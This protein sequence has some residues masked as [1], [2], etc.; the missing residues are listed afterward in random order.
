MKDCKI[1]VLIFTCLLFSCKEEEPAI[2]EKDSLSET[3]SSKHFVYY[4]SKTDK[5]IID[6]VW[7][8]NYYAW[9][10]EQLEVSLSEKIQYH[11]Y[12]DNEHIGRVTGKSGNGF[13]ELGTYK[14]HTIW[15]IDNHECVHVIATQ[16]IGHPPALF[17][18]G[19]AVA[20]QANYF[21]FPEFIPD[22]NGQDFNLLSRNYKQS[23]EIPALDKLLGK[24][25]YWEYSSNITY[26]V[27]GSFV[28][29]L[30][31]QYSLEK[32]KSFMAICD[33]ND[34]KDKIHNDFY[35]TYGFTIENAWSEWENFI[36]NYTSVASL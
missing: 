7:Q 25:S 34:S 15:N 16:T 18:E 8:E 26:P 5:D 3:F 21:K 24:Y 12:R 1:F 32:M 29:F 36:L 6:T 11:K 27:S 33:F 31:N 20:Y 22:W 28:R 17:N 9:L 13:A 4:Y 19:I 35:H 14:V 2:L 10:V 30:I 23:G